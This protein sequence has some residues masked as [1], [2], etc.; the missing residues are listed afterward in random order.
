MRQVPD[1]RKRSNNV[2][3]WGATGQA[4][5]VRPILEAAGY[6]IA[7]LF[8]NDPS[9]V[10]PF[11]DV[12]I[13]GGWTAFLRWKE[14]AEQCSFVVAVGGERRGYDRVRISREL[15]DFG[16]VPAELVHERS[17]VAASA[18]LGEGS[19]IM[20]LA[21]VGECATIGDFCIINTN[22]TIDH[23]CCLGDGVHVM[24]GVTIAGEVQIG[25][26]TAIGANATILPRLKIGSGVIV[27][28]GAVVTRSVP[29]GITVVGNPARPLNYG[30]SPSG[31]T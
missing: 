13:I 12:P 15:D 17:W 6:H 31:R 25:N 26:Y 29:D 20:A 5:V 19:Q 3:I 4:K 22:A 14:A 7:G 10:T 18:R 24:P 30:S 27:G 28:A 23:D 2:I 11:A 9:R 21:G 16:F 1:M 8:D